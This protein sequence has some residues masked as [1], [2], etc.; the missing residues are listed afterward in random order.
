M[1][2][3]D[4]ELEAV[5]ALVRQIKLPEAERKMLQLIER[6]DGEELW[7]AQAAI[8]Q[9]IDGFLR[10]RQRTLSAAFRNR[11]GRENTRGQEFSPPATVP[12]DTTQASVSP[13][14]KASPPGGLVG[15][16]LEQVSTPS[17]PAAPPHAEATLTLS[18][19]VVSPCL[20]ELRSRLDE[21]RDRY[22]FQWSTR[23]RDLISDLFDRALPLVQACSKDDTLAIQLEDAFARHAQEIFCRG[24]NFKTRQSQLRHD[25]A[26]ALSLH[27]LQR[28]LDIPLE[29]YVAKRAGASAAIAARAARKI[30]SALLSGI[31]QGYGH[32]QFG[33]RQGWQ[34]L[35]RFP[36]SWA[37]CAAFLLPS[38][39]DQIIHQLETGD[40]K[41]GLQDVVFPIVEAIDRLV[42]EA[43]DGSSVLPRVGEYFHDARR[44]EIALELPRPVAGRRYLDIHCYLF[45]R[46]VGRQHLQES[47]SRAATLIALALKPDLQDWIDGSEPLRKAVIDVSHDP[48]RVSARVLELLKLTLS[49]LEGHDVWNAPLTHNF[50]RDFPLN[51]P[52]LQRSFRVHR[53][54]V[55]DQ[56]RSFEHGTGIRLWCSVRRSGK[57]TA[58]FNL[59]SSSGTTT[60]V[61]QTC[62][63]TGQHPGED[64]FIE[65]VKKALDD[66]A[67]LP[68]DFFRATVTKCAEVRAD[69]G[70]K[71]IFVLDE[72]ET[73]FNEL[74]LALE[75]DYEKAREYVVKPML[76]QIV[77]FSRDNLVLLIGMQPNAHNILMDQNQLSPLV[78]QDEFPLF[79]YRN[80]AN[81]SE[82]A[83]LLNFVLGAHVSADAAFMQVL[84]AET[85]GHPFLTVNVLVDLFEWLILNRRSAA[86]LNLSALDFHDFASARLTPA[87]IRESKEYDFFRTFLGAALTP[88]SRRR[89][90]W[91]YAV[92]RVLLGLARHDPLNLAFPKE[93][94]AQLIG[95]TGLPA[96]H[97]HPEDLLRTAR[98]ANF[99]AVVDGTVRPRIPIMARIASA[100]C[101]I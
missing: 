82:F 25:D 85:G 63:P 43:P 5:S 28:F 62:E 24:Y 6:L 33:D 55:R 8:Q 84:H 95:P 15:A 51:Q 44:L 52:R 70:E 56:L 77:E 65:T 20:A 18:C 83:S 94:F 38:Q 27:G 10:K 92:C 97:N 13:C 42:A 4:G 81:T 37:N 86:R 9:V 96:G 76:N 89:T 61:T 60:V 29:F 100:A 50:A 48:Q 98:Q 22:I 12:A 26:I 36:G 45:R 80:G 35:P 90:P 16:A 32:A 87:A 59:S 39:L 2:A 31:V 101:P 79:D 67:R 78:Q 75:R 72:Y 34:L 54:S 57:T 93:R 74:R 68:R 91:L 58:G 64:I 40:F 30:C 1:S 19:A 23:Y 46:E 99:L 14:S 11:L 7:E 73:L 21:L 69:T 41:S 66:R 3:I 88:I 47:A 71:I 53:A 17:K 49:R